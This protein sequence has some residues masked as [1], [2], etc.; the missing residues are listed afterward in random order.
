MK[1]IKSFDM[2]AIVLIAKFHKDNSI[3]GC[4]SAMLVKVNVAGLTSNPTAT[5]ITNRGV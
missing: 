3:K 5:G 4:A 1:K 2:T